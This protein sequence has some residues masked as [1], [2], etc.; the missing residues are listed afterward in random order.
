MEPLKLMI[1]DDDPVALAMAAAVLEGQGHQVIARENALGTTAAVVQERPDVIVLDLNMP[2][3]SGP[4]LLESIREKDGDVA[5]IFY[6]GQ[7]SAELDRIVAETGALGAVV[8]AVDAGALA[9]AFE[10]LLSRVPVRSA[11]PS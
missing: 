7:E 10:A 8:K 6:S 2:G 9:S 5:V 3:L 4:A 11:K 1:V